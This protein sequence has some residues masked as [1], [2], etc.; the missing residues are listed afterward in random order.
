MLTRKHALCGRFGSGPDLIQ[1]L[2]EDFVGNK[3]RTCRDT[4]PLPLPLNPSLF[5]ERRNFPFPAVQFTQS[6]LLACVVEVDPAL[7]PQPK[8]EELLQLFFARKRMN[9]SD[10]WL[11]PGD[12]GLVFLDGRRVGPSMRAAE[13]VRAGA[14]S[15]IGGHLPVLP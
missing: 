6:P 5:A 3:V 7:L 9:F 4:N 14:D 11:T 13:R 10:R 8:K 15:Y 1:E 12:P 2:L